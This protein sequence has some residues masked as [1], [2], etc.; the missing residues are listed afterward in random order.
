M[1]QC[2]L[3]KKQCVPCQ[4]GVPPLTEKETAEFLLQLG[5]DWQV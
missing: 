5:D 1:S 4:G 2:E 3:S